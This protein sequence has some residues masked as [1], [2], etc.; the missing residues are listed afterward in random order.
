MKNQFTG[1]L[2]AKKESLKMVEK[3]NKN[4]GHDAWSLS[5]ESV[6]PLVIPALR[7]SKSAGYS[8]RMGTFKQPIP[9][10]ETLRGDVRVDR[11]RDDS[12]FYERQLSGFTLIELLVVVLII[13]ILAAVAVPQYQKA[14]QKTRVKSMLFLI[15]SIVQA[16]RV[17]YLANNQYT[18]DF[19]KLDIE[20]PG[21]NS[22]ISCSSAYNSGN[23]NSVY[24][25]YQGLSD[26]TVERYYDQESTLCWASSDAAK[27][28]CKALCGKSTTTEGY[29]NFVE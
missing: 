13:G 17:Y 27:E 12:F 4:K 23:Y 2:E 6:F 25:K 16:Q 24:C 10:T 20:L 21:E 7:A 5:G 9:R 1:V 19:S 14:V 3:E 28:I 15:K 26:L 22:P 8:G 11:L 29:C 18:Y